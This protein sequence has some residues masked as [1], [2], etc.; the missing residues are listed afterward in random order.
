MSSGVTEPPAH[1]D[2]GVPGRVWGQQIEI[3]FDESTRNLAQRPVTIGVTKPLENRAPATARTGGKRSPLMRGVIGGNAG[4]NASCDRA[5]LG[6]DLDLSLQCRI[7]GA[8]ERFRA[9]RL[10][11]R[12]QRMATLAEV[13]THLPDALVEIALQISRQRAGLHLLPR[14]S[15][16]SRAASISKG[17]VRVA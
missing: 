4:G 16:R 14:F 12:H 9:D 10:R 8:P 13:E 1:R 2:E 6:A 5:E 11:Q 3:G 17:F 7:V 15:A